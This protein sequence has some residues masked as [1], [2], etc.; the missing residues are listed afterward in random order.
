[1]T[2]APREDPERARSTYR[3]QRAGAFVLFLLVGG[4]RRRD[5]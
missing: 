2:D 5:R 1:M 4:A 3:W